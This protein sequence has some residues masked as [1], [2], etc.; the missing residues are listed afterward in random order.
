MKGFLEYFNEAIRGYFNGG[1]GNM[2]RETVL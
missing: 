1:T 2:K